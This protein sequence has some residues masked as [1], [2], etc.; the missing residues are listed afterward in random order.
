[1]NKINILANKQDKLE[2]LKEFQKKER[3]IL[4]KETK[5]QW[6]KYKTNGPGWQ[7]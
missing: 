7:T 2:S 6:D 5:R 4:K 3:K 1:M